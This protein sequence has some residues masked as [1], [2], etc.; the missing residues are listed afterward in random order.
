M[1]DM[2]E[3]ASVQITILLQAIGTDDAV[4]GKLYRRYQELGAM[5]RD[6]R[7]ERARTHASDSR[8][9][10]RGIS[11]ADR[12]SG[13]AV[14]ASCGFLGLGLTP[15]DR[16]WSS[17]PARMPKSVAEDFDPKHLPTPVGHCGPRPDPRGR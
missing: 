4:P 10:P 8:L 5:A 15:C 14:A 1:L 2:G 6:F 13:V 12:A 17:M 9:G 3:V 7:N 11:Q 16:S